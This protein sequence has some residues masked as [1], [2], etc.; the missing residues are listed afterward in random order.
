MK[1]EGGRLWHPINS[2]N[3]DTACR[4]MYIGIVNTFSRGWANRGM[5]INPS[6][7][8]LNRKNRVFLVPIRAWEFGFARPLRPSRPASVEDAGQGRR[9]RRK[10]CMCTGGDT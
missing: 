6:R 4:A 2:K 5:I 1:Q 9:E 10:Q 8:Q 3:V 7:G